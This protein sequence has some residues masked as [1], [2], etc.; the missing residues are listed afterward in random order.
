MMPRARQHTEIG[1]DAYHGGAI[2]PDLGSIHPGLYHQG[3]LDRARKAGPSC[4]RKHWSR[5]SRRMGLVLSSPPAEAACRR[6][7]CWS[8]PMATRYGDAVAG[9]PGGS[10]RRLHGGDRSAAGGGAGPRAAERAHLSGRQSQHRFHAPLP[11]GS[12]ILFGGRTG[13]GETDP[14]VMAGVLQ[15]R[16]DR[17]LPDLAQVSLAR[18]W[19]GRCAGTFDLWPHLGTHEGIT[20]AMGYC[21]AGVPMGTYLGMKAARR[22]MGTDNAGTVFADRPFPTMPLYRGRSWLCHESCGTGLAGFPTRQPCL[23]LNRYRPECRQHAVP[24]RQSAR[25]EHHRHTPAA[26]SGQ[27]VRN[28]QPDGGSDGLGGS[29]DRGCARAAPPRRGWARPTATPACRDA[30]A[31][32]T[33]GRRPLLHHA[34]EI[35]HHHP[36]AQ[37]AHHRQVVADE[38]QRQAQPRPQIGEELQHLRLHRHVERRDRLVGDQEIRCRWPAPGRCRRAGADRRENSCG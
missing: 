15:A 6:H 16:L 23:K 18:A 11:D 24:R 34:A 14:L 8:R 32:R 25:P 7:T 29:P 13:N 28:T 21:F 30:P 33:P 17:L 31:A 36:V 19:T 26:P 10:V 2:V 12:R 3:L 9:A 37:A 22:I 5:T 4:I 35:H 20:Y 38:Q 1:S 27:R